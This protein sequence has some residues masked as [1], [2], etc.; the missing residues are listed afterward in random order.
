M[1]FVLV[2]GRESFGSP[3]LFVIGCSMLNG[4]S[5]EARRAKTDWT[6]ILSF[7]GCWI[8]L[9]GTSKASVLVIGYSCPISPSPGAKLEA[10]KLLT[11][12][13]RI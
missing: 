9:G 13:L 12:Q 8:P 10:C 7:V 3:L 11:E 2:L 6:F 1:L 4:L 5:G